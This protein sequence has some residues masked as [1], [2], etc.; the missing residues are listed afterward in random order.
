MVMLAASLL[1]CPRTEPAP[2]G[3]AGGGS[4][5]AGGGLQPAPD[6]LTIYRPDGGVVPEYSERPVTP[7]REFRCRA[8]LVTGETVIEEV[9]GAAGEAVAIVPTGP[10]CNY[11]LIYRAGTGTAPLS[12]QPSGYLFAG[13]TRFPD[14]VRL[15]CASELHHAVSAGIGTMDQVPIRCWASATTSGFAAAV[16]VE[17]SS[18]Y[19]A[20]VRALKPHPMRSGAYVL[21]WTRDFSFQ[22]LNMG[23]TGRP[24]TDGVYETVLVWSGSTLTAE[25]PVKIS[26]KTSPFDGTTV[27]PFT[28]TAEE[29]AL[30]NRLKADVP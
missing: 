15:V 7:L 23:D 20:W 9:E 28:P 19:A 2:D 27:D 8:E 12:A 11:D 22:F 13:A 14:G 26:D 24:A 21:E 29:A 10:D 17:G 30:L 4:G 5:G 16:A 25:A 18:E 6:G 1:G 3:G